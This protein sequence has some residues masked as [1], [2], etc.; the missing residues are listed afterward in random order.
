MVKVKELEQYMAQGL[1]ECF[2]TF[3]LILIGE[4]AIA[5]Y[6]LSHQGNHS[7]ITINLSFGIGVY[8]ALM[9]AGPISGAHLNPAVS[10]SL[11][12]VRKLKP[13]QCIIYIISQLI[14]AF[15]GALV[16]YYLYFGLFNKFDDGERAMLGETGTADIFFTMPA[17]GVAHWN[18]FFD[19]VVGTAV[20]MIF[21]MALISNSNFMI[22][23]VAKPFAFVLIIVGITSAFAGNAGAAINPARDFGPRLFAAFIYGWENV[24]AVNRCFFWIPIIG[25]IVG[26]IIGVWLYVGYEAFI[27][28]YGHLS[29]IPK[30][31]SIE[32][33]PKIKSIDDDDHQAMISH[34]LTTIRT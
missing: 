5:Q 28:R 23:E 13:V 10:I 9:I 20:L 22:S 34:E 1:A 29:T 24:F 4:G 6:K 14:G 17:D 18:S 16:V 7:T 32:V 19:Q 27:K 30:S 15:F 12:T 8:T 11:L 21:I 33:H 3:M 2:A 25:P 26:A 31:G